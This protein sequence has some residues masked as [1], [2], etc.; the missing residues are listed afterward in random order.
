MLTG[1]KQREGMK[2]RLEGNEGGK[3]VGYA[4]GYEFQNYRPRIRAKYLPK[5]SN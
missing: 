5:D 4:V 1:H 3:S 2:T